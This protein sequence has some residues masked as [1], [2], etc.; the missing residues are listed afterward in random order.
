MDFGYCSPDFTW[1][2]C[3]WGELIWERLDRGVVNYDWLSRFPT[4]RVWHLH[5]YTSDHCSILL[6]LDSNGENQM[7]KRKPFRFEAMWLTDP[8]CSGVISTIWACNVEGSPVVVATKKVA[9]CKKM[10]KAWNRDRFGNVCRKLK[11]LRSYCGGLKRRQWDQG[12]M[13]RWGGWNKS[14]PNCMQKKKKCGIRG[15]DCSG[16]NV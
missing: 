7:W 9:K 13:E 11:R 4:G 2:S 8:E 16:C 5:C 1:H 10:L 15:L 14:W 12:I 3:H 6:S